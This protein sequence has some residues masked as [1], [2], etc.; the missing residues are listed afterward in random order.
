MVRVPVRQA[1]EAFLRRRAVVRKPLFGEV[2]LIRA[3]DELNRAIKMRF[4]IWLDGNADVAGPQKGFVVGAVRPFIRLATLQQLILLHSRQSGVVLAFEQ[5]VAEDRRDDPFVRDLKPGHMRNRL[6]A[7]ARIVVDEQ[8]C[9]RPEL[10]V[11]DQLL[12]SRPLR[13]PIDAGK[14]EI[15]P[16][17][18]LLQNLLD[19]RVV[20]L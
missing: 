2:E 8:N 7:I 10:D 17:A 16:D 18:V 20:V 13:A 5:L 12:E 1:E 4:N 6:G 15:V 19:G 3:I 11:F 9:F 14:N